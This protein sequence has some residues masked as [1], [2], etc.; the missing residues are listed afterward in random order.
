MARSLA[1]NTSCPALFSTA[2]L[3]L[4]TTH[5]VLAQGRVEVRSKPVSAKAA[6]V[7]LGFLPAF[8]AKAADAYEASLKALP[9][10]RFATAQEALLDGQRLMTGATRDPRAASQTFREAVVLDRTQTSAWTK[11]AESL[12]LITPDAQKPSERGE[13]AV[14]ATSAALRAVETAAQPA[15]KAGAL[16]V[17][18]EAL[19][20]RNMHR[21]AI[22]SLKTSLGLVEVVDRRVRLTA[23]VA[24]YG[25]RILDTKTDA[26]SA[27]PRACVV[28]S[29]NLASGKV[30]FAPFIKLDGKDPHSVSADGKQLCVDGLKHGQRYTLQV[31]A[32]LPSSVDEP[33]L[34]TVDL[35][36]GVR[37]RAPTVRAQGRAYVLPKS[38]QQGLPLTTINT[39]ALDVEIY[40]IGDRNLATT[41]QSGDFQ[42]NVS[43]YDLAQIRERSGQRV[44]KG[45]LET[46]SKLND[47]VTTAFPVGEAVGRL[48]AGVYLLS[49]A[50]GGEGQSDSERDSRKFASQWFIV[51]DLGISALSG[52]DGVHVFVRSLDTAHVV[53]GAKVRLVARNNEVLGEVV[54]DAR[55]YVRFDGGLRRGEGGL[56]PAF[57]AAEINGDYAFLDLSTAAFDLTDRGVKGRD[58]P[59][60][61]DAFTFADRGVYRPGETVHLTSLV[62]DAEARAAH[63][64]VTIVIARPDGVEH[65]RSVLH[66]RGAGGRVHTLVL[67]GGAMTGTWRARVHTDPKADAI[68]TTAFL[69]EDFTPERLDL[70]LDPIST[71]LDAGVGGQVRLVGKYLYGPPAVGLAIEGDVIVK[72]STRGVEGFNGYRFG[73]SDEKIAP[74][75]AALENLPQTDDAGGAVINVTLPT[76]EKTARSLDADVLVRLREPG[77]RTIERTLKMPVM[78]GAPRIGIKPLFG[79]AEGVV[80]AAEGEAVGFDVVVLDKTGKASPIKGLSWELS[81]LEQRWQWYSR[82]GEW[83][84]D[85]QTTT[86]RVGSGALD[87]TADAPQHI[88]AKVDFGRY[89]L[90]VKSAAG[91]DAAPMAASVIFNAGY[92]HDDG[93]D[94]PEMLDIALD[95]LSFRIG[96]VARVRVQSRLAGKVQVNVLGSSQLIAQAQADIPAGGGEVGIPVTEQWGAGAYVSVTHYRPLDQGQKRMPGRA[97]GIKWAAVDQDRRTLKVALDAPQLVRPGTMMTVPIK[98]NGVTAGDQAHVVVA[99]TDLGILNLTRYETPKP[100]GWFFGQRKLG[101]DVRDFY[102]RLIDG[103]KAERGRLRSGGD[104]GAAESMAIA[105]APPV[106]AT[107][108]LFSGVVIVNADGAASVSFPMPDF[109]GTVR[110]TAVAWS[111]SG[112]GHAARDVIVRDKVAITVAGPRFLTLGDEARLRLDLNNVEAPVGDYRVTVARGA[113]SLA[114][115]I[116]SL[117]SGQRATEMLL[118][119][120][121]DVG[122]TTVEVSVTGP[123]DVAIKRTLTFDVKPP[124]GNIRRSTVATLSAKG[125]KLTVSSDVLADLVPSTAKA[126]VMVGPMATLNVPGLLAELDRY[127]YGCAEQTTSRALPLLYAN[128]VAR[129]IGL[130]AD[131][132][133]RQRVV[134]AIARLGEMQDSS[135]A[136]G[137]WGPADGDMWLSSYVTDF[138]VRARE[139]GH[140]VEPKML[141]LA[142]DKLAN[143]LAAAPDGDKTNDTRA[144]SLYVLARAGRAPI[145]EL[146]YAIDGRLDRFGTALALAQLGA[147]A[148][149]VGDTARAELAFAAAIKKLDATDVGLTR[150]DY[151]SGLRDSAAVLTLASE[152]RIAKSATSSLVDVI[153]KAYAAR[154]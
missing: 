1:R 84:Y 106:E 134:S 74:M 39:T 138:L 63:L 139:A 78:L 18:H 91:G 98:V 4:I 121:T 95:K 59:G 143:S 102:A 29:E 10:P 45:V 117:K 128:D 114:Q 51:S 97:L 76:L 118:F 90:D 60:P 36:I 38:G 61:V 2:L 57:V 132:E 28:F 62:R 21:A 56:Q 8:A 42:R 154:S 153:A 94:S 44:Y 119:K 133:I 73:A 6:V 142:L 150:N 92:W 50:I 54:T 27:Q 17:M 108:A 19:K 65:S 15:D 46:Q 66:D 49:A 34:K 127:P 25:F 82:D 103:M 23:L 149:L 72:P 145:G 30:D 20:R 131:G 135:G 107:L 9:K 14:Q 146:K 43:T 31:R 67:S 144:Y 87:G 126:T 26:D 79:G 151:G 100:E 12:L 24:E 86:R 71:A 115:S 116:V 70:K 41:L 101:H 53:A 96:D 52:R 148:G 16:F 99:A 3:V 64:P 85:A 22:S 5:P 55:G 33:L 123:G 137:I 83:A 113:Q 89:R 112:V 77:G 105:G 80:Q 81:R 125:G 104:G 152:T 7:D 120:P 11:L 141:A 109:N 110:L 40:R 129:Q 140:Q 130:G 69:V 124:A 93:A 88:A 58:A 75:R 136:F 122:L 111:A 32:G 47:E 37:D 68:S 147:A 35:T 48:E 13:L